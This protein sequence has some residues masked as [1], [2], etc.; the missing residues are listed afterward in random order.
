MRV[1]F[2]LFMTVAFFAPLSVR[3]QTPQSLDNAVRDCARY[4][5]GRF[6]RGT[7]AAIVAVQGENREIGEF[8]LR[9]LGEVLVNANWFTVVERD[10]AALATIDREMDRHLDFYVSQETELFIGRQLGAQI[11]ISGAMTRSGQNWR[12]DVS[13]V[14]VETAQ[15]AAQWSAAHI[16]PDSSWA[17]FASSRSAGLSFAG[18]ALSARDM[19]VVADGLRNAMQ[20]RNVAL[21]LDENAD[22]SGYVFTVTVFREQL[23]AV[24]P[25]NVALLRIEATVAFSQGG[26]IL[27]RTGPYWITEMTDTMAMRRVAERLADD[28]AFFNSI[29]AALR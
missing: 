17:A 3:A 26:R 14:T 6:P 18:D 11:I 9:K 16:R 20:S 5:Q 4:L 2:A 12:L 28:V 29:N 1:F 13:A 8:V 27:F 22:G 24:P 23:P 7:R 19:R 10:A 25:A 15:R 21:D